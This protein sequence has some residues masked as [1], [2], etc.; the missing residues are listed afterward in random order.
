[1]KVNPTNNAIKISKIVKI[2]LINIVNMNFKLNF[3]LIRFN[4]I[5][6]TAIIVNSLRSALKLFVPTIRL[7][8]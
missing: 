3:L 6:H 5:R 2:Y 4:I 7:T 8:V 1:M